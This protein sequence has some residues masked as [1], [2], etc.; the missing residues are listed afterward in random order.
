MLY[1]GLIVSICPKFPQINLWKF[2]KSVAATFSIS[3]SKP[4]LQ[5][6]FRPILFS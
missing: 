3:K 2:V 5:I 1:Y 6:E 4:L